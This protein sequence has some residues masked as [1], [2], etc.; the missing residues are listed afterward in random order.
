LG[1]WVLRLLLLIL[2]GLSGYTLAT[3][4][5][6]SSQAGLWGLL[7][8]LVLALL[9]IFTEDR[10]RRIPLKTLLQSHRIISRMVFANLISNVFF[11]QLEP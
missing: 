2:C 3:G 7:G 9:T 5:S 11:P 4:W 6:P 1:S 10:L 8:G